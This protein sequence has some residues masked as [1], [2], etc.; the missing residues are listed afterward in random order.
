MSPHVD[1]FFHLEMNGPQEGKDIHKKD[2][3]HKDAS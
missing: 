3:K 2:Q 1:K